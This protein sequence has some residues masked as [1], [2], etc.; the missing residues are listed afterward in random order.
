MEDIRIL[1]L[2]LSHQRADNFHLKPLGLILDC[3]C[4][5]MNDYPNTIGFE[6]VE[7]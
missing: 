4:L 5:A 6:K 1:K 2:S 3:G 7:T